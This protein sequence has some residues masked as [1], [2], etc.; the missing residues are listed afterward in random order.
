MIGQVQTLGVAAPNAPLACP[1]ADPA[2]PT[3]T[4]A[5]DRTDFCVYTDPS[6]S[7]TDAQA[8]TAADHIEDKY[9][10]ALTAGVGRAPKFTGELEVYL[11]DTSSSCNG[12]TG[13]SS[14]YYDTYETCITPDIL[15]QKVL[16]H[17]L[18]HRVQYSWDD[19][20]G[21]LAAP[22]KTKDLQG[23]VG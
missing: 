10:P 18:T 2:Y 19:G 17:E 3:Y 1:A 11:K 5:E 4:V 22:H 15:F 14:N 8:T 6:G 16:G 23:R 13:W 7:V 9:W 12:G 21:G 20:L